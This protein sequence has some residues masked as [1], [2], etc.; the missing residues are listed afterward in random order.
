M[1]ESTE[2]TMAQTPSQTRVLVTGASGF[3]A[4]HCILQLLQQG[5]RV[6]GTLRTMAR[7]PEVRAA[8]EAQGQPT[9]RLEIVWA[10][11]L[12]DEGW[13]EAADGCDYVLHIASPLPQRRPRHPDELIVPARDGTL[14]VLRAASRAGVRRV[15][16]TSSLAAVGMGYAMEHPR[17]RRRQYCSVDTISLHAVRW[18]REDHPMGHCR[19]PVAPGDGAAGVRSGPCAHPDRG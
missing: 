8:L 5:Y 18:Y 11:L 16:V 14:R 13:Q 9:D 4:Q 6:R 1:N 10:N 12:S 7:E 19:R 3:I 15:I 17:P 2:A